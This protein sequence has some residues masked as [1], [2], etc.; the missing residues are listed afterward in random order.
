MPSYLAA[1]STL[2]TQLLIG[3]KALGNAE[4]L[5]VVSTWVYKMLKQSPQ[6]RRHFFK[7]FRSTKT[8][9]MKKKTFYRATMC[10]ESI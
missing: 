5:Y 7:Q 9:F 2:S 8:I 6:D 10:S 4:K 3:G 1:A